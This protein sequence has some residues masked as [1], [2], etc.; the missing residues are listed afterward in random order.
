MWS[1][2]ELILQ[3]LQISLVTLT[4]IVFNLGSIIFL[5]KDIRLFF[6]MLFLINGTFFIIFHEAGMNFLPNL[7]IMLAGFVLMCLSL[8]IPHNVHSSGLI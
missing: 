1:G 2:I 4:F 6:T 8:M 7:W 5:A 3:N